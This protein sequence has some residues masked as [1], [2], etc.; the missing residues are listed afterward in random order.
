MCHIIVQYCIAAVSE[1]SATW[2]RRCCI[3]PSILWHCWCFA[4]WRYCYWPEQQSQGNDTHKGRLAVLASSGYLHNPYTRHSLWP[5]PAPKVTHLRCNKNNKKCIK[6]VALLFLIHSI[7][8]VIPVKLLRF[9]SAI[10]ELSS[11]LRGLNSISWFP[12]TKF[13]FK[14]VFMLRF[15]AFTTTVWQ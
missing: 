6:L 14:C 1:M 15:S 11:F 7:W 13:E 10:G 4:L 8:R 9:Y 3:F 5:W 2:Q 12:E